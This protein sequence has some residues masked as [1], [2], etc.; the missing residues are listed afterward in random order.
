MFILLILEPG[1]KQVGSL[2]TPISQLPTAKTS[3]GFSPVVEHPWV[4]YKVREP[5]VWTVASRIWSPCPS[6]A[7]VREYF[8]YSNCHLVY[9]NVGSMVSFWNFLQ[10]SRDY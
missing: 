3:L 7:S 10:I 6:S 4:G 5:V 2:L 9:G 8:K 1:I